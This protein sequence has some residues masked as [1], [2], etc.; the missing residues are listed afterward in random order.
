[1]NHNPSKVP[2]GLFYLN[3]DDFPDM[4][5]LNTPEGQAFINGY[6]EMVGADLIIF[7][8]IQ[9]LLIGNMRETDAWQDV[10]PWSAI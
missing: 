7:D 9:S 4:P 10:L 3:R 2:E 8:N 6:A 1:M 5:P